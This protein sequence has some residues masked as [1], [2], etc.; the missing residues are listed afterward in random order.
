[1]TICSVIIVIFTCKTSSGVTEESLRL[2]ILFYRTLGW[3]HHQTISASWS[4]STEGGSP[5]AGLTS[6]TCAITAAQMN[7]SL[8]VS[9]MSCFH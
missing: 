9:V 2:F 6:G 1:M 3:Y 5:R 7:I 4:Q 8:V